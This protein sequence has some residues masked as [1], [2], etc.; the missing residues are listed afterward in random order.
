MS[1]SPNIREVKLVPIGNSKGIRIPKHL[2]QKYG[3]GDELVLEE[4]Q[5]GI[6][7]RA[8]DNG[9]LSWEET[10]RDMARENE[11]WDDFDVATADG[12]D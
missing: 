9:K 2:R 8:S 11:D 10:Y 3:W 6:M 7:L 12:L 4:K 1:T 5:S